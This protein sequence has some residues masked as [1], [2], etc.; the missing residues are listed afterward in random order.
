MNKKLEKSKDY[1]EWKKY[2]TECMESTDYC[3]ISTVDPKGVW[4]NPVY[5]AWDEKFD[6]YFISQIHSRHM[7]NLLKNPRVSVAIYSTAQKG[8]VSGI[9]LEGEAKILML[10]EEAT[11]TEIHHAYETYYGRAGYGTDVQGY[12]NNPTWLY[13]RIK[14]ESIYYFDTRFFDE[15]RQ[16]VPMEKLK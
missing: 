1:F 2:L 15:E 9:Q 16:S 13:V 5:F 7:Q 14:P 6:L 11:E 8:D 12:I 4:S 10:M 3:C